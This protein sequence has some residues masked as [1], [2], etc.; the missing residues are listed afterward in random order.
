MGFKA[1]APEGAS[2]FKEGDKGVIID[3]MFTFDD[4][5]AGTDEF[6]RNYS[7]CWFALA[8][9]NEASDTWTYFGKN[10]T[11]NKYLGWTYVVEWYNADGIIIAS[12]S[13]KINLSNEECHS[14]IE[15]YYLPSVIEKA[16]E[17][18][19]TY[20]DEQIEEKIVK[21]ESAWEIVEF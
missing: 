7:I 10:S 11:A 16:V 18:A 5:F 4:A 15:P 6:G 9:Y 17:T 1:Y 19:K 20:V 8:S 14:V 12:D 13:I 21:L 3:E 2:S